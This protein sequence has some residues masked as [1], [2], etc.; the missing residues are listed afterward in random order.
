MEKNLTYAETLCLESSRQALGPLHP[1]DKPATSW[2]PPAKSRGA[3]RPFGSSR[4]TRGMEY[5]DPPLGRNRSVPSRGVS[6]NENE[7]S[8]D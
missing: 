5:K 7:Y 3:R 8:D 4:P 6:G 1:P 2:D